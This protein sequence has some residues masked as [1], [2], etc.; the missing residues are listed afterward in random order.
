MSTATDS[1]PDGLRS[2]K[3]TSAPTDDPQAAKANGSGD[4]L[5]VQS[6]DDSKD[7]QTYGRTP[8]GTVFIVPTTHDMVSD[9]V[10]PKCVS[11]LVVLAILAA[12]IVAA[13]AIPSAW[14][15]PVF[16]VVFLI[17]RAAYNVGIG[18]LLHTQSN[19][20]RLV[21]WAHRSKIFESPKSGEKNWVHDWL[22]GELEA[23]VDYNFDTA[24]IEYNTWLLFRKFVDIILLSDFTAYC[25]FAV[26]CAH[27]PEGENI[28]TGVGRWLLGIALVGFNVW[29]KLDAHRVVKDFAWYWGDFFFLVD[30]NLTFDGV[31]EVAPHPMY[32]IGYVGYYGIS[33]MA[34]SYEVFFIS[35][36]AHLSQFAFLVT[37]ETPHIEK[38][39]NRPPPRRRGENR[40]NEDLTLT[41]ESEGLVDGQT[42]SAIQ[43]EPPSAVHNLV[44]LSNMDF[45]RVTDCVVVLM[46]LYVAAL[47]FMAPST[48]LWQAAFIAHALVW[49]IWYHLGLGLI[50]DQQSRNKLWSRHFLKFGES[51]GEAWRQW[52]ALYHVSIIMCNA[53]LISACW[54]V[55]SFPEDWGNGLAILKHAL[56][57][58]LIALQLWTS[59]SVYETLGEFGWFC[60]DFFYDHE[61]KLTYT[62]IY[63]YL[64]NPERIFGIAGV[65]GAALITWSRSVFVMALITQIMT[66]WY[67]AYVEQPHMKKVYGRS[68]RREAGVT[69]FIKRSL[70]TPVKGWQ[71]SVDK[72]I[73]DTS[74]IVE[75]LIESARPKFTSGVKTI[76]RDT[77][78]LFNIAPARLTITRL[79]S[80]L[81]GLDSKLYSLAVEGTPTAHPSHL[82]RTSGKESLDGRFSKQI[83]TMTYEY[84]APLRVKWRAPAQHS[85]E[86][87]IGL[88]MVT[89]N[90]SREVTEVSS[91]GRWVPTNAESWDTVSGDSI[92]LPE[93]SVQK[94]DPSDPDMV[95]GMVVFDGDKLWWTQGVFEFRYHHSNNHNV[96]AISEPF[97]IRFSKFIDDDVEVDSRGDYE[98]AIEA[99]LL[100]VVQ[101]CLDR[102]PD[103]APSKADETFGMLVERDGKYAKRIVYAIREMFGIEFAPGVVLADGNVKR[104]AW[105]IRNA[106]EVLAPYSLS[107]SRG[108]STPTTLE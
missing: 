60:G 1:V 79:S 31:F 105:R 20:R 42:Q 48:P 77:S 33:M 88:Y 37:V 26:I 17:W 43:K 49:R 96:M 53:S 4:G 57:F 52:K 5:D 18:A 97:E 94:H 34:A 32:S 35:I 68:L 63:R 73:D 102:D 90:R 74:H 85:K 86:D 106:K 66:L 16:A 100:P 91:L 92:V 98:Q 12:H 30:Q 59:F 45:F 41:Q 84:G 82:E 78:A 89:D 38:T 10:T 13:Y 55:Y 3:A 46:P 65:W 108:T 44:G 99:A 51:T 71:E 54:K 56:G 29:V 101:N 27:T 87:W 22:K 47:T 70:P 64:N 83:K 50:L 76:V 103:I 80:D 69:K 25:L 104:L 36:I 93:H 8:D 9:L 7:S 58:G 62:S 23:K 2:R 19:R 15:R 40:S 28:L 24:P 67:V 81:E 72:V 61:A 21:S 6:S 11:D 107:R 95:E 14:K 39:Y 75:D